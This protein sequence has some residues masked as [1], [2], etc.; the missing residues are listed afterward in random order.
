[1]LIDRNPLAVQREI[2]RRLREKN[3]QTQAAAEE[4][5]PMLTKR[6]RELNEQKPEPQK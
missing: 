6:E 3:Q 2:I 1:M 5:K 4:R